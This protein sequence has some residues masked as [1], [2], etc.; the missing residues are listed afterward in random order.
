MSS[1]ALFAPSSKLL[2]VLPKAETIIATLYS[3]D[4]LETMSKT[5]FMF[6]ELAT[7]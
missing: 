2:V 3:W 5:F 7:D 6:S 1:K 4:V